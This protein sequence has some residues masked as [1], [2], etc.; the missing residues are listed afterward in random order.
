YQQIFLDEILR[1][2]GRGCCRLAAG[3]LGLYECLDCLMIDLLC[4]KCIVRRHRSLPLHRVQVGCLWQGELFQKCS[5]KDLGVVI[6]LDHQ[7]RC[8][9][10]Q[11]CNPSLRILDSTGIHEVNLFFCGCP[12]ANPHYI[13][14]LR[15]SLYPAT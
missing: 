12:S 11:K 7:T 14:L 4:E 13:Q 5:L 8:P 3:V 1:H 10:P 15:R 9:L 6:H 2:D